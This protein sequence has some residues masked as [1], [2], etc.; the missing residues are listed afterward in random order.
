[1]GAEGAK[2]SNGMGVGGSM[3][4]TGVEGWGVLAGATRLGG[5]TGF[6][7]DQ[8]RLVGSGQSIPLTR[9]P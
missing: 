7:R 2:R 6:R 1:M 4:S 9:L 5:R 8:V 3:R